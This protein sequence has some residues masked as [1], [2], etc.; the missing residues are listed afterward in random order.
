[1]DKGKFA[2]C[3]TCGMLGLPYIITIEYKLHCSARD[4]N[5]FACCML[6][7]TQNFYVISSI[8]QRYIYDLISTYSWKSL[9]IEYIN[10]KVN[11]IYYDCA[12]VSLHFKKICELFFALEYSTW[13]TWEN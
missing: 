1:M 6:K 3:S 13:H 11:K 9:P 7:F 2:T 4:V 10:F 12:C 8:F 5:S